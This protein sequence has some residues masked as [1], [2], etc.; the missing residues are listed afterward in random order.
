MAPFWQQYT[1]PYTRS[2]TY[3][4]SLTPDIVENI[5]VGVNNTGVYETA[6]ALQISAMEGNQTY[7]LSNFSFGIVYDDDQG[8]ATSQ[9]F[10][11]LMDSLDF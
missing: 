5:T 10:Q 4:I 8:N 6:T 7:Q 1:D 2:A 3:S 9:Y 11:S